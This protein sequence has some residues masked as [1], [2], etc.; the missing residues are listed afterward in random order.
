MRRV[1]REE[2]DAGQLAKLLSG[3]QACCDLRRYFGVGLQKG[4]L[5]P[6]E[7]GRFEFLDGGGNRA[8]VCNRFT[9]SDVVALKLLSIDLPARVTLDL[10]EGPL[11]EE[12][13]TLLAQI[14]ASVNLWDAGAEDLIQKDGAAD[15]L[16]RLLETQDGAGWV[17]AGKLLAR[18]RP[19]LIPVYDKI[20]RC[21]F[22]RPR[23]IWTA[24]REA[25][26]Q[27]DSILLETL[28]DLRQRAELPSQITPLRVLDVAVWMRHRPVHT[29]H[30]CDGLT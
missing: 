4:V 25:L 21:A 23:N 6:Y 29:G 2:L 18:K 9:A 28:N 11:G 14:P 27:D 16:W 7:G 5:P 20:V 24:L 13:A 10:L 12:A 22:G 19:G 8:D 3:D 26:R 15:R 1:R 17:T 30:R